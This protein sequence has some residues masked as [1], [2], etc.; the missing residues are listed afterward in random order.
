MNKTF[1]LLLIIFI[2]AACDKGKIAEE[3]KKETIKQTQTT[4]ESFNSNRISLVFKPV[5]GK[6][7][8]FESQ[9]NQTIS[10]KVD[11]LSSETKHNQTIRYLIKTIH[12][13]TSGNYL[14][15]IKFLQIK[16]DITSPMLSV[17]SNTQDVPK[18]PTPLD[19]FYSTLVGKEFKLKVSKYGR[20][21]AL[22]G[23]DS[24][25]NKVIE[26]IMNK[27]EFKGVDKS[28]LM[29]IVGSFFNE[30]ELKKNFEKIFEIYP[31]KP[32]EIGESWQIQKRTSEPIPAEIVNNFTLKS[33]VDDT[34]FVDLVSKIQ[35][36]KQ[37]SREGEPKILEMTGSQNGILTLNIKHGVLLNSK[38][39][40]R[41]KIVMQI[42]PSQQTNNK[43]LAITTNVLSNFV[44]KLK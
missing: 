15:L 42:P 14:L 12:E 10:Q 13:D 35:F 30:N 11:T 34:A 6:E 26:Q 18:N 9:M 32:V 36:E 5:I 21:I 41:I 40:Q 44:L 19:I 39:Q 2:F 16:Q 31:S 27:K 1:Y 29:Q 4:P 22:L 17:H 33:I 37:K 23:V 38:L 20:D 24:V 3:K 7:Y 8:E 25:I 43:P 28:M